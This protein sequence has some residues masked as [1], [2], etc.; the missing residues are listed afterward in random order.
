MNAKNYDLDN[1]FFS[2]IMPIY[3]KGPYIERAVNSILNQEY[4]N[5]EIIIV[6]DP[7]TDNSNEVVSQLSDPR[8]RVFHRDEPGP[9]GYAARNLGIKHAKADWI[10]FLDADDE[11]YP[12]RLSTVLEALEKNPNLKLHTSIPVG[13]GGYYD[14]EKGGYLE[15]SFSDYMELCI[16]SERPVNSNAITVNKS[17]L[18]TTVW[19]PEGRAKR[20]GDLYL[21]VYL[22]A[23][24]KT[25]GFSLIETSFAHKYVIGVSKTAAPSL[26]LNI[27]LL[28]EIGSLLNE[29]EIYLLRRY[30]NRLQMTA[31]F[32]R[33]KFKERSSGSLLKYW[34]WNKEDSKFLIKWSILSFLPESL[35]NLLL[36][37]KEKLS[38]R[39]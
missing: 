19:F 11:Y 24:A 12:N 22:L 32:E 27:E 17:L 33:R 18:N 15:L 4:Q 30:L 14:E 13:A 39:G 35:F 21:W 8:I 36:T 1:P 28:N 16:K 31:W 10:C 3:N 6:C 2:V 9:G 34:Y 25:M 29:N 37:L 23:H 38:V 26:Q 5:F 7:S 20:S